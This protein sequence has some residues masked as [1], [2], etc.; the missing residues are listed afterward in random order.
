VIILTIYD[1]DDRIF[2]ALRER[3]RRPPREGADG[4]AL[5]RE[6]GRIAGQ[7][8]ARRI[9]SLRSPRFHE[10]IEGMTSNRRAFI[11]TAALAAAGGEALAWH[12]TGHM[13]VAQIAYSRL[14]P[15]AKA[16]VEALLVPAPGRRPFIHL[17]AGFYTPETCEKT[18][19]PV[20]IAVW[21]DDFRGDSLNESY[22]PWHYINF[23]PIFDGV[24]ERRNVGP[25][26]E[27][28]LSRLYW[29]MN[30]LRN[31]TTPTRRDAEVLGFLYHLAGD[32]HQP[33]HAATRY[34]TSSPDGDAGGN[35]FRIQMPAETPIGNL[36]AFWDAAGG[37]FG[38]S[39]IKRPLD[40]A[41]RERVVALAQEIAKQHPAEALT[42][43]EDLDPHAWVVESNTLA[44]EVAYANIREGEAPTAAYVDAAQKLSRRRIAIAGYR[45][46]GVLNR[47]FAN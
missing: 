44:R 5:P 27:N 36:H 23:R 43:V 11:L 34:S 47:V 4:S 42:E 20:T 41:G 21:M 31:S 40:P 3:L 25:E 32:V 1:D 15:A 26:P 17:C 38:F 12:D 45:L 28:V 37:A 35:G 24:P 22:A 10:E 29:T 39:A 16:R 13:V 8:D 6:R 9:R 2:E 46:A 19:D 18:Y 33:L 7:L 14:T 30:V